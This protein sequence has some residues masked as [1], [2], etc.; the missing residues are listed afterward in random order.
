M[1][2]C[3]KC[4]HLLQ[5]KDKFCAN[6]GYAVEKTN[7]INYYDSFYAGELHMC[8]NCSEPISSFINKCPNCG[9]ELRGAR[10]PVSIQQFI[11]R[12]ETVDNEEQYA[13]L[14]CCFSIPNT[15]EDIFE[16]MILA[17]TSIDGNTNT[18]ISDAWITKFN[19]CYQ[20]AKLFFSTDLDFEKIEKIYKS[21]RKIIVKEKII[22]RVKS[23]IPNAIFGIILIILV[24]FEISR[25]INGN[26]LGIDI[27]IAV[28]ILWGTYQIP[29]KN[30]KR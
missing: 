3:S 12:L 19:Q 10:A 13:N 11:N 29:N 27:I 15:K 30:D 4:G 18:I 20:K 9:Y 1:S 5:K 7:E 14:I 21:T 17:S 22:H 25:I 6:C 23:M 2:Y 24:V 8:P 16:Y 28:L 26:F